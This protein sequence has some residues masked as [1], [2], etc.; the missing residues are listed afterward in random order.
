MKSCKWYFPSNSG[1]DEQGLNNSLIETFNDLPIKS[2]ARETVQNSLDA[3]LGGET[4]IVEFKSFFLNKND[5]PNGDM[6]TEILSK[7]NDFADSLKNEKAKTFFTKALCTM[8]SE[9]IP[10]LRI[11]DFNTRGLKGSNQD[12]GTDWSNLVRSTGSSNKQGEA[13]GSFGIGK[14]APFACSAIRTVFYSTLDSDGLKAS[15]GVSR[16][17]SFVIGHFEDGTENIAQGTGYWGKPEAHKILPYPDM[18]SLDSSFHRESSGTDIYIAGLREELFENLE[19]LQSTIINEV[20]D[21]FMLAICNGHLEVRV[22]SFVLN[23]ANLSSIIERFGASIPSSTVMLYNLLSSPLL[24]WENIPVKIANIDIGSINLAIALRHD[25]NNK[26]TM[27]RSTG[28]KIFDKAG[29]CP[30]MRFIG[31]ALIEGKELNEWL[32]KLENP[33]HN[34]WEPYRHEPQT[35]KK[36]LNTI[37]EQIKNKLN[38]HAEKAFSTSVD[39]EGAGEFLPDSPNADDKTSH[40]PDKAEVTNRI[41]SIERKTHT[42]VDSIAFLSTLEFGDELIETVDGEGSAIQGTDEKGF[43]HHGGTPHDEGERDPDDVSFIDDGHSNGKQSVL[44]KAKHMRVF[45]IDKENQIYRLLFLPSETAKKSY[46]VIN[47]IAELTEKEAIKILKVVYPNHSLS[48]SGNKVGYFDLDED[49]MISL[50]FQINEQDY[51][52]MEVKVYAYKG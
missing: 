42:K 15:E 5:F 41:V 50:D 18:I 23:K 12:R 10:F 22:N 19:E 4:V 39:I 29:L 33:S 7:C 47:K 27:V 52:S 24:Q 13:G 9:K 51:C 11:S 32:I 31:I 6:L 17:T 45:C 30:T 35:S 8:N 20:L 46:I 40:A 25:G 21:G 49:K 37:F 38:E 48:I 28:M 43:V 1:G 16:L 3:A 26:I 2:L 44:V 14:G 34:K 36:L